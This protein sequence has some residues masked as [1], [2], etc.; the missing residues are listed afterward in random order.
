MD[1]KQFTKGK[2]RG[3]KK[4]KVYGFGINDVGSP[5]VWADEETGKSVYCPYYYRWKE[6]LKRCYSDL[7][8]ERRPTY[9][10]CTVVEEWKTF[11]NFRKWMVQQDWEG[12]DLDKDLKVMGNKV[13]GPEA[14]LFIPR[15]VNT[16]FGVAGA[17]SSPYPIGV[18]FIRRSKKKPFMARLRIDGVHKHLGC[19]PTPEEA[20]KVYVKA[21]NEYLRSKAE[22]YPQYATYILARLIK[23][24]D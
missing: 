3:P 20:A 2:G 14:C 22:E 24:D 12:M 17:G 1:K 7:Y 13:Y 9:K 16:L 11:S 4:S 23:G 8:H 15:A 18:T 5:T 10:D 21:R 19:Y 6:M